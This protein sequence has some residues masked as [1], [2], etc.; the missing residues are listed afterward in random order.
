MEGSPI[1]LMLLKPVQVAA[2]RRGAETGP[3]SAGTKPPLPHGQ[4]AV[5]LQISR[6]R[7]ICGII[8]Y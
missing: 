3:G 2:E 1:S 5:S 6:P 7:H 4:A 8:V